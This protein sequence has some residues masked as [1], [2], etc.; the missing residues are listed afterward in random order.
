[1]REGAQ[2]TRRGDH[3]GLVSV[4]DDADRY[5]LACPEILP[6]CNSA[7]GECWSFSFY[8]GIG[9]IP[10]VEQGATLTCRNYQVSIAGNSF[11][12]P[13]GML[14]VVSGGIELVWRDKR[15]NRKMT[16]SIQRRK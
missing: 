7:A 9:A 1:M 14:Q 3:A 12:E 8:G 15:R 16:P 2:R 13:G 4:K 5:R 10:C 6:G 11:F